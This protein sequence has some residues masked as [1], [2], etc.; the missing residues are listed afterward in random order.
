[1]TAL[2][3]AAAQRI[4]DSLRAYHD[5]GG[6]DS[7]LLAM[8]GAAA[9]MLSRSIDALRGDE[10]GSGGR[11]ML[12]PDR[13]AVWALPFL[14]QF[15]GID[16]IP[17]GFT[18]EQTRTLIRDAPG[19]RRGT[20]STLRSAAERYLTGNRTVTILERSGGPYKLSV[21]TRTDETPDSDAVLAAL[22][23]QKPAGIDLTYTVADG[24][25]WD[26]VT[27]AWDDVD[28]GTTWD[29]AATTSI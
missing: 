14:S 15:V 2:V 23:T 11:R 21:V 13:T 18:E 17:A 16:T 3:D 26:E 10:Y 24:Q 12:D 1:M 22:L 28:P 29:D 7:V 6:D 27:T 4:Y 8:C 9:M 25:V 20:P 19:M 5:P